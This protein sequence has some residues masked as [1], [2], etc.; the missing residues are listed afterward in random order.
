MIEGD[1][2]SSG[3]DLAMRLIGGRFRVVCERDL[4]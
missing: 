2:L 3:L 1:T 4:L